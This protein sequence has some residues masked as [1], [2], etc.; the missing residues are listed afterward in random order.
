MEL[1]VNGIE[2]IYSGVVLA[3][4]ARRIPFRDLR[5]EQPTLED[6][7]LRLTGRALRE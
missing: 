7:F 1:K 5:T 6:V 3:L 2:V 4:V